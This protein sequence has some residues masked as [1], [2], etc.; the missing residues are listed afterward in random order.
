MR[1]IP[2][3]LDRA[4]LD[5][6]PVFVAELERRLADPA[7]PAPDEVPAGHR[8]RWVAV[9]VLAAAAAAAAGAIVLTSGG[10]SEVTTIPG[11]TASP[12][13]VTPS[14]A[15][16]PPATA[17]PAPT[18]SVV[19]VPVGFA[20]ASVTFVSPTTGWM[21]GGA[22]DQPTCPTVSI[23]RTDDRGQSWHA[24]GAP[25]VAFGDIDTG[26]DR[27]VRFATEHDGYVFGGDLWSTHDG[28]ATW[29][30]VS[31]PGSDDSSDVVALETSAGTTYAVFTT[32]DGFRVASS[33]P[34]TDDWTLDPLVVPYGAGP[35]PSV[36]LVLQHG[37]GW[38]IEN[39]RVV[40]AGARLIDGIWSA[41]T[42]PCMDRGG[43]VLLAASDA[44]NLAAVCTEGVWGGPS[45]PATRL[46]RS[47]DG[48]EHFEA[49]PA[50]APVPPGSAVVAASA[51]PGAVVIGAAD[52]DGAPVLVAK[53][54]ETPSWNV[55][56]IGTGPA[57]WS[58]LGFTTQDQGVVVLGHDDG[59]AELLMTMDGGRSWEPVGR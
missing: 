31:L 36:Q 48:G 14:S 23:V 40:T 8:R 41:W 15:A 7:A 54:D 17:P 39:D 51:S 43:P 37:A 28:A 4:G 26:G 9:V 13:T 29:R 11:T 3:L 20:P 42:P 50:P 21:L 55:V 5:P 52:P 33:P 58:D 59:T 24:V 22:C 10:R 35:V 45:T 27:A 56:W 2:D 19:P 49:E 12:A 6:D 18:S 47:T 34:A 25:P 30:Q 16:Q 1:D 44:T 46:Y 38:L 32:G 57:R 53:L